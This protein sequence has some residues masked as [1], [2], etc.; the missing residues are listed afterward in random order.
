MARGKPAAVAA[1]A[2]EGPSAATAAAAATKATA[3]GQENHQ[4]QQEVKLQENHQQPQH[5]ES[6]DEWRLQQQQENEKQQQQPQERQEQQLVRRQLQQ[7]QL[8]QQLANRFKQECPGVEILGQESCA[9]HR[10]IPEIS[11][12]C[13]EIRYGNTTVLFIRNDLL[14]T[15]DDHLIE[16][17]RCINTPWMRTLKKEKHNVSVLLLNRGAHYEENGLFIPELNATLHEVREAA[18]NTLVIY[19]ST[20]VGHPNCTRAIVNPYNEPPDASSFPYHWGDFHEQNVISKRLVREIGGI[21]MDVERMTALRPDGH[22]RPPTDCL[23]Y[24]LPGP[25]DTWVRMFYHMLIQ[26]L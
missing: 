1:E 19:R 12:Q 20:A 14:N 16:I 6:R 9:E 4:H 18:P 17:P 7:Q 21:F 22:M 10:R 13:G 2:A 11:W 8:Q 25:L 3:A 15:S 24:C 5:W 26:L 23:H